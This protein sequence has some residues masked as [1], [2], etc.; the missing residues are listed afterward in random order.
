MR[1]RGWGTTTAVA[2]AAAALLAALSWWLV[3]QGREAA[4]QT[5]SVLALL[6]A[7][8]LAAASGIRL[9]WQWSHRR[10]TRPGTSVDQLVAEAV[11]RPEKLDEVVRLL[12]GKPRNG[13][14]ITT[15][16]HGE[17]GFGKTMLAHM[18]CDDPRIRKEFPGRTVRIEIGQEKRGQALAAELSDVVAQ[19]TGQQLNFKSA[20]EAG[21]ALCRAL[22]QDSDCVL[23]LDD[24]WFPD[25]LRPFRYGNSRWQILVTTRVPSLLPEA[26]QVKVDQMT[27]DQAL[28]LLTRRTPGLPVALAAQLV[29]ACGRW[30]L[31]LENV[32]GQLRTA[33]AQ[34]AS[35][36][37]DV[38]GE[39][40]RRLREHGPA[41][42][43]VADMGQRRR[44][45]KA[46]IDAGIDMQPPLD[47]D[48]LRE[49]GVFAED[50]PI[51]LD[52]VIQLWAATSQI[53]GDPMTAEE[54]RKL[55]E[56]AAGRSLFRFDVRARTLRLHD[57]V[58]H[59]FRSELTPEG[60]R[61]T[62]SALL[63][64]LA[65]SLP[66]PGGAP[67][68]WALPTEQTYLW[69]HLTWHLAQAGRS[70]AHGALTL[71]LR[72]ISRKLE[73]VGAASLAADL[74]G[75]QGE[76]AALLRQ[77]LEQSAHLLSHADPPWAVADVLVRRLASHDCWS[78]PVAAFL[79]NR[80]V[81]RLE[82][83]W[84]MVD[85]PH[86]SLRR[87]LT[88]RSGSLCGVAISQ[89]GMRLV[90]GNV[91]D[92]VEIWDTAVGDEPRVLRG[93]DSTWAT[94]VAISPDGTWVLSGNFEGIVTI[95]DMRTGRVRQAPYKHRGGVNA[96]AISPD[97]SWTATCG[98]TTIVL[99]QV[100]TKKIRR[101]RHPM[102]IG[103][104]ALAEKVSLILRGV[105]WVLRRSR[106][107]RLTTIVI[108][109]DGTWLA[110]ADNDGQI[111]T[112]NASTGARRAT[113]YSEGG[114][115]AL[116]I[117]PDG[118]WLAVG[119]MGGEVELWDI[120]TCELRSVLADRRT[121]VNAVAIAPDGTWLV[122]GAGDRTVRVWDVGS[123]ALRSTLT[124][125]TAAVQAVAIASTGSWLASVDDDTVRIW[126]VG[127]TSPDGE[128][129]D[130]LEQAEVVAVAPDG[131]HLVLR[132]DDQV[133][134]RN[135]VTDEFSRLRE[136][137]GSLGTVAMTVDS[138]GE[139]VVLAGWSSTSVVSLAT[140]EQLP[141]LARLGGTGRPSHFE[142]S[143]DG[144]WLAG[145][146]NGSV[147]VWDTLDGT[148]RQVRAA[149]S[150]MIYTSYVA[151]SATGEVLA[152][153]DEHPLLLWDARTG[154]KVP[155]EFGDDTKFARAV[156][157]APDSSWLA[158]GR[159]DDICIYDRM[160]G[161]ELSVLSGHGSPVTGIAIAPD[162]SWLVSIGDDNTVRIWLPDGTKVTMLRT[163][164]HLTGCA[165]RADG[166]ICVGTNRGAY[167]FELHIPSPSSQT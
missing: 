29:K 57:V 48:R 100:G 19:V 40:L 106:A 155:V 163:D 58:L 166:R 148:E 42:F 17:G 161:R 80:D 59:H 13:V 60:L 97:G 143:P 124:G 28:A 88:S 16:L 136:P 112:W 46:T 76:R 83:L 63:D 56:R 139:R 84:P 21:K 110:G 115:T 162:S 27:E 147:T 26:E 53:T 2:V 70:D 47:H 1:W 6:V 66:A 101:L 77:V 37:V 30:A 15:A 118:T 111:V 120:A 129:E 151:W 24:V 45:V 14:A 78:A 109:A 62:N 132:K 11:P 31:L 89:D 39:V 133:W 128:P 72:W 121:W 103:N 144:R 20:E 82:P 5:A 75:V 125:H 85:A 73:L 55:I 81:P 130:T 94:A 3:G 52:V 140:G 67:A 68:W 105:R 153:A 12:L 35:D 152:V 142:F 158:V 141:N 150:G 34:E 74:T 71:D 51:P 159:G 157:F 99:W 8:A 10:T 86:P 95:R 92:E 126:N 7:V 165:V 138:A 131:R 36:L 43:D 107:D 113:M 25:Q 156:A 69:R 134:I 22:D 38:G 104:R 50:T 154:E 117:S 65:A 108:A 149:A 122:S 61:R 49:L 145:G 91:V 137:P 93:N 79:A 23:L 167:L 64:S 119:A 18:V 41:V 33:A 4:D 135:T 127:Q 54:C 32:N 102:F 164:S 9:V 146:A 87:V 114:A 123:G 44:A 98:D 160:L 90:T 116:A 96:V